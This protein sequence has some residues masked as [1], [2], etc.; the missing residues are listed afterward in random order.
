MRIE[1]KTDY[2]VGIKKFDTQ[3]KRLFEMLNDLHKGVVKRRDRETMEEVLAGLIDYTCTHFGSEELAMQEY[4]YPDYEEHLAEHKKLMASV[5]GYVDDMKSGK[6]L[7]ALDLGGFLFNW[8]TD[9]I[10]RTDKRMC[11]FLKAEGSP[12]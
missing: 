8:L 2:S 10:A 1:W 7:R 9:H 3:H 5:N 12:S 11:A 6:D 4:A